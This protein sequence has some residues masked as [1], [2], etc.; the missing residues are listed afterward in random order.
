MHSVQA[1]AKVLVTGANGFLALHVVQQLLEQGYFVRGTVRSAAKG[2]WIKNKF[3]AFSSKLEYVIVEDI[4]KE[5]AFD[6]AIKG[7]DAVLHTASPVPDN[8]AG[9]YDTIYVPAVKGTTSIFNSLKGSTTVKRVVFTSSFVAMMEPHESGYHYTEADWN[10]NAS[11]LIK[12]SPNDL[13]GVMIY[14]AAKTDAE[15]IA[16]DFYNE[17]KGQVQW[18]LVT[19]NPPY[20]WGPMLQDEPNFSSNLVYRLAFEEKPEDKVGQHAGSWIDVRDTAKAHVLS[21][22]KEKAGGERFLIAGGAF[23]WQD[24]YNELQTLN[25][26]EIPKGVR[27]DDPYDIIDT[28]KATRILGLEY[29]TLGKSVRDSIKVQ[30]ARKSQK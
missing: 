14:L 28:S 17:H 3:P 24:I 5:G 4:T 19:L 9:N 7:M 18:D 29:I 30:L 11:T 6:E 12:K 8:F 26:P 25:I 16:W 10:N 2:E 1:P 20:I 23:K 13:P 27:D 21:L 22:Q 15:H